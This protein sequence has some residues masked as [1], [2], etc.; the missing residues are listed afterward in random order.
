MDPDL[1]RRTG[2]V[3]GEVAIRMAEGALAL[4]GADLAVATT[5]VAGPGPD[6][7][8][9]PA[10][11]VHLGLARRGAPATSR[12]LRLTGDRA[13]IRADAVRAAVAALAEAL[14]E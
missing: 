12:A 2:A 9:V 11:T 10:G 6:E 7:R 3:T 1:L 8:G 14:E 5:G 13:R 4:Y